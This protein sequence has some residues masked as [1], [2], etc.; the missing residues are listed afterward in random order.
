MIMATLNTSSS[1][2]QTVVTLEFNALESEQPQIED[3]EEVDFAY[4]VQG[5]HVGPAS[6]G[7]GLNLNDAAEIERLG[8]HR[9]SLLLVRKEAPLLHVVVQQ[10]REVHV[11]CQVVHADYCPSKMSMNGSGL[12][13]RRLL[14]DGE[15]PPFLNDRLLLPKTLTTSRLIREATQ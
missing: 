15:S 1:D 9:D 6:D 14:G 8:Q 7:H 4:L 10:D 12:Q 5:D 13:L 3:S 11:S 2:N